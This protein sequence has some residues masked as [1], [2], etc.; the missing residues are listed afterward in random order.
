VFCK[1]HFNNGVICRR[2][3]AACPEKMSAVIEI[4]SPQQPIEAC[5]LSNC[6]PRARHFSL[7]SNEKIFLTSPSF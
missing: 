2:T 6:M 7:N 3:L 5:G 1:H 4:L